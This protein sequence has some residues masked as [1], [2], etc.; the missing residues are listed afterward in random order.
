MGD[1]HAAR[2]SPNPHPAAVAVL[3]ILPADNPLAAAYAVASNV[4]ALQ[5]AAAVVGQMSAA[6]FTHR[7]ATADSAGEHFRHVVDH[8]QL[9]LDGWRNGLVDYDNRARN[10]RIATDRHYAAARMHALCAGLAA[11]DGQD[12]GRPVAVRCNFATATAGQPRP[13]CRPAM[14]SC[15]GRELGFLHSHSSHHF[16]FIALIL[17]QQGVVVDAAFGVAPA[18]LAHRQSAA[19]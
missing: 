13:A 6:A 15:L 12:L 11:L 2:E 7:A 9:F 8:Y 17:R 19:K 4:A 5:Q 3:N 10:P 18:T 16:A 1:S 14:P